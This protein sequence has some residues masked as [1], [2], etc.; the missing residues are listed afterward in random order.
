MSDNRDSGDP[1]GHLR[2]DQEIRRLAEQHGLSGAAAQ[3]LAEIDQTMH[4]IRRSMMKR[5]FGRQILQHLDDDLEIGHMDVIGAICHESGDAAAGQEPEI[6]VGLVADRLSIDPSRASRLVS[7][8]VDRGYVRRVASQADARRICLELSERG[9]SF[10]H[11]VRQT[12][13]QAFSRSLGQWSEEDLVTFARLL[14]RF[15]TWTA[16]VGP[17]VNGQPVPARDPK[18]PAPVE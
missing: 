16:N 1:H 5:E 11:A 15:S 9:L 2:G 6:T 3:A 10:V 17:V 12:K 13:W 18:E 4:R 14:A 7:E 8:V